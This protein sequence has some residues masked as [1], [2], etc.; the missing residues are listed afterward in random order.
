MCQCQLQ[1]RKIDEKI[2]DELDDI[3]SDDDKI[4][5]LAATKKQLQDIIAK[6]AQDNNISSKYNDNSKRGKNTLSQKEKEMFSD[7]YEPVR[8]NL[9]NIKESA[10]FRQIA[11]ISLECMG[12]QLAFDDADCAEIIKNQRETNVKLKDK[13]DEL[14]EENRNLKNELNYY[15]RGS[16]S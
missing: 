11:E 5:T 10:S 3:G 7:G 15:K 2:N 9:F 12:K 4:K 1:V 14:E 13:V 16:H 8:P 6:L